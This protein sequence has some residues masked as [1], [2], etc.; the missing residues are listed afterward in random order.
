MDEPQRG[1][2][3]RII[4]AGQ[5]P[6]PITGAITASI[7]RSAPYAFETLDILDQYSAKNLAHYEYARTTH[8]TARIVE[9]KVA[10]LEG[11]DETILMA[12][13]MATV[14]ATFLAHLGQG[15]HM[16]ITNNAYK[17]TIRFCTDTLARWGIECSLA[18]A[19]GGADAVRDAVRP[20]TRL[21]FSE[22]P[23]NPNLMVGDIAALAE[24]TH[25]AGAL[26]V[27]DA[28]VASPYN[29]RPLEH[30]ADLVLHSATKYLGG[31]NDLVAGVVSGRNE[32]LQPVRDIGVN[33]GATPDPECCYLLLRGLKTLGVRV[34]RQNETAQT[35]AEWLQARDEV[36]TVYYPGLP[37]HPHHEL[38]K[39]QM[40]GYGCM[41]SFELKADLT[42]IARFL[43]ALEFIPLAPSLGGVETL[44]MH[45]GITVRHDLTDEERVLFGYTDELLRLAVGLEDAE[46]II[47]DLERGFAVL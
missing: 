27:I 36:S 30:G 39:R 6:D 44:I 22:V 5:V 7:V 45:P 8:P 9:T 38:A 23:S 11:A 41:L 28:T 21:V 13:G 19:M 47:G 16:V 33:L 40:D 25:E 20:N 26:L 24:A 12:S 42:A 14:T 4:H 37:T 3:T 2:N 43:K 15:D 34:E 29:L 17:R 18:D 32:A 46:D 31:H 1:L 35:V 10:D